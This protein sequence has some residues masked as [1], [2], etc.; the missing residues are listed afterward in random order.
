V[1]REPASEFALIGAIRGLLAA[2]G[3]GEG[4][5]TGPGDDCA[6]LAPPPDAELLFT[7][8]EAVEGVHFERTWLGAAE[9][10]RRTMIQNLSDIAA[11]AGRPRWAVLALAAPEPVPDL[12]DIVEGA[13][14][15]AAAWGAAVVGGNVT[16]GPRLSVTVALVGEVETGR[17]VRRAGAQAGDALYVTGEPGLARA[18]LLALARGRASEVD[19]A[20]AAARWRAPRPRIEEARFLRDRAGARAMI[21][22]SD[23]LSGDLAHIC[24]ESGVGALIARDRLPVGEALARAARAL[25][26]D[27][28]E[29]VLAGGEDYEL[30]LAAP[31]DTAEAAR[32]EFE[33]RFGAA[34]VRIGEVR[35]GRAI[36]IVA[37]PGEPPRP[38]AFTSFQH[39]AP[40]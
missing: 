33:S 34:L 20:P 26:E 28:R 39:F 5:R 11:M 17:A 29:L 35:V 2:R 23:G 19:L 24:E 10:G 21:D 27:P 31:G 3:P 25:G 1:G 6:V 15:C 32:A 30:L 7:I 38:L 9:I 13:S 16:R 18:G 12:L 8:D 36:E 14:A 40:R 4:V 22:L 37:A